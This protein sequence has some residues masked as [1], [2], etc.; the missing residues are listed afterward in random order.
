MFSSL[1]CTLKAFQTFP[2]DTSGKKTN[3][4]HRQ[5]RLWLDRR[6]RG[7]W[8]L[9]NC[10]FWE[11]SAPS[12]RERERQRCFNYLFDHFPP[13]LRKNIINSH[14]ES[15][16]IFSCQA[17][18]VQHLTNRCHC[19]ITSQGSC[20]MRS[21]VLPP[22]K[23]S[24]SVIVFKSYNNNTYTLFM[25]FFNMVLTVSVANSIKDSSEWNVFH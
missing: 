11:G 19:D 5:D 24:K 16:V 25:I 10:L 15:D 8:V 17:V 23:C 4:Q 1:H 6:Q 22:V 21:H 20:N 9:T 18:S 7:W 13:N 14:T 2:D 12:E 3:K